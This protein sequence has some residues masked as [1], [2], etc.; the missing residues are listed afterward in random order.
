VITH[1]D[2]T[3]ALLAIGATLAVTAFAGSSLPIMG[4]RP[5]TGT[6]CRSHRTERI[7]CACANSVGVKVSMVN[8]MT[9][10]YGA[11]NVGAR[12]MGSIAVSGAKGTQKQ[13]KTI[14][15]GRTDAQLYAMI[16]IT[17][18]IGQNDDG[19][20]FQPA[21]A[22]LITQFA[23]ANG[24]GLLSYWALQRDQTGTGNDLDRFSRVNTSDYQFYKINGRRE[25][26][27]ATGQRR[28]SRRHVHDSIRVRRQMRGYQRG[29][30][31]QQRPGAT[32]H[33]QWHGQRF[34]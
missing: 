14:F 11:G 15:T 18:M 33:L 10:D 2:M 5:W 3:I 24:V 32:V 7:R 17:P 28:I 34:G 21:D 30:N 4:S 20:R 31:R 8:I 25:D 22:T 16:G 23:Q 1:R 9:M 12:A 6:P 19:T 29:L 27:H 13:L 26:Q